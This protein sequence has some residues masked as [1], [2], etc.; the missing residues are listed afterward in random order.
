MGKRKKPAASGSSAAGSKPPSACIVPDLLYLGPVSA[1][2]NTGFLQRSGITHV[3]SIGKLPA[4]VTEG[5]S[6]ERLSLADDEAAALADVAARA[7]AVI[8]A[9]AASGGR[10]LV[11]CSAA[12]SRSPAVVSAYLMRS[13]GMTLRQSLETLVHARDAVSPNPGFMRQLAEMEKELFD[14]RSSFD[15]SDVVPQTRLMNYL[16]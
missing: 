16:L 5:I 12:I 2:A 11:H 4:T 8:D 9:A 1:T 15:V 7:C 3:V 6:Y 13:R 14:G 10:V